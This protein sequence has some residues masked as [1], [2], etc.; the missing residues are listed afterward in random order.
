M[1]EVLQVFSAIIFANLNEWLI[2]KF[3]LHGLGKRKTNF[4]HFHWVHHRNCRKASNYDVDYEK[5]LPLS[6][7]AWSLLLF[8]ISYIPLFW[9]VPYFAGTLGVHAIVYY[10]THRHTHLNVEWGRRWLPWH[11]DHHMGKDQDLNWCVLFP[12]WDYVLGTRKNYFRKDLD[13]PS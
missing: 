13:K 1:Y 3:V 11:H 8:F 5:L 9:V 6:R 2:H 7:E 4:F 10:F 12:L